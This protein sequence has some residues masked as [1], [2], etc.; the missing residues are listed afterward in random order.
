MS[1]ILIVLIIMVFF[2][3]GGYWYGGPDRGPVYASNGLGVALLVIL[4]LWAL[5]VFGGRLR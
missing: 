1:L 5:G 3:G 4:L 2:A